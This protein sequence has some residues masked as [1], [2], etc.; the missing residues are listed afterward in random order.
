M[1]AMSESGW[2][3]LAIIVFGATVV[4][5][6]LLGAGSF[7]GRVRPDPSS[8]TFHGQTA[9]DGK[10]VFQARNCMDCHTLVGNG[11]YF[12]PDIT[13]VYADDG[14]AWTMAFFSQ[15]KTWPTADMTEG[16]YTRL[17]AEGAITDASLNDYYTKYAAAEGDSI[18]RG[19]WNI[20]MPELH[21]S[22]EE[23]YALTAYMDYSSRL[24]TAGWPPEATASDA[25]VTAV[26]DR[27]R[28]VLGGPASDTSLT[29]DGLQ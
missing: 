18:E 15:L 5:F 2:R 1:K 3:R 13:K 9:V 21:L 4:V 8:I 23:A 19:G 24:N 26:Q 27:L 29:P 25:N 7:K 16:W 11:A 20:L 12:G 22:T 17:R 14:P 10:R 28:R 6:V